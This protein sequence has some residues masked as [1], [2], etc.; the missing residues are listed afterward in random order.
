MIVS[1]SRILLLAALLVIA[2]SSS[3][4]ETYVGVGVGYGY[5]GYGADPG[6]GATAVR[7]SISAEAHAGHCVMAAWHLRSSRER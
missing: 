6:Q 3:G 1:S 4:C 5:P 2:M 7:Q